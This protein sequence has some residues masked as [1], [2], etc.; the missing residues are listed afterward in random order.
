[1]ALKKIDIDVIEG[2]ISDNKKSEARNMEMAAAVNLAGVIR[3]FTR[4]MPDYIDELRNVASKQDAK[5]ISDEITSSFRIAARQATDVFSAG[6]KASVERAG[7]HDRVEI[8]LTIFYILMI[9]LAYLLIFFGMVIYGNNVAI[10]SEELSGGIFWI[11][12]FWAISTVICLL[13][14]Y[15]HKTG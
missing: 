7:K 12:F 1:M 13:I 4:S 8:P 9:T 5:R 11:I 10:H 2:I 14:Q 15:H 3:D 6:V